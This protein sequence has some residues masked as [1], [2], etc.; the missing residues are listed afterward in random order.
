MKVGGPVVSLAGPPEP[1]T[2][3]VDLGMGRLM[4][5]VFWLTSSKIRRIAR[6]HGSSYRYLLMH[7]D[8][9]Q[10]EELL[11]M[12]TSGTLTVVIDQTYSF[13]RVLDAIAHV[14]AGHSKGKVVV[15][16]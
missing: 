4:Q 9:A 16:F 8:R 2:A 15:T 1:L 10:L 7:P 6:A 13:D 5:V 12:V 11:T 3:R 14:E